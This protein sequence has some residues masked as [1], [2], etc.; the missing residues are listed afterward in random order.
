MLLIQNITIADP[1]SM[2][3]SLGDILLDQG[4]IA[5]DGVPGEVFTQVEK[6]KALGLDVP[7]MAELAMELRKDGLD[8]PAGILTVNDMV[9]ELK[10]KL[11]R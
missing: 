9:K 2:T 1:K 7:P 3:E 8:L 10:Q 5:L 4:K 11:C 6:I